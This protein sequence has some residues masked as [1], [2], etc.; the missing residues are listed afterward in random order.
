MGNFVH[1]PELSSKIKGI[2]DRKVLTNGFSIVYGAKGVGMSTIVDSVIQG[3]RGV[4]KIQVTSS[5]S[6]TEIIGALAR[7]NES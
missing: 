6:R 7:Y 3:R 4:I 1:R 2:L 5:T